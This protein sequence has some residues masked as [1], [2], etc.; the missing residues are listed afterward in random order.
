MNGPT[1]GDEIGIMFADVAVSARNLV[2]GSF[3]DQLENPM[4]IA[5]DE[6]IREY[7]KVAVDEATFEREVELRRA[8]FRKRKEGL[9]ATLQRQKAAI[10]KYAEAPEIASC[11]KPACDLAVKQALADERKAAKK[12]ARP[13]VEAANEALQ[14][15]GW[16]RV[17]TRIDG[18]FIY[19]SHRRRL[20]SLSARPAV[21]S[22]WRVRTKMR[23]T[24]QRM[25]EPEF[26]R[27]G[28]VASTLEYIEQVMKTRK[29]PRFY[30]TIGLRWSDPA[31]DVQ[32]RSTGPPN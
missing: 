23:E 1:F 15:Q 18:G 14:E 7:E 6:T 19:I 13:E 25:A 8:E 27:E 12:A 4:A 30:P 9:L 28:V 10:A 3:N 17:G 22:E 20:T 24:I 5:V 2:R 29:S 26:D 11:L 21:P 16:E 31:R 32:P